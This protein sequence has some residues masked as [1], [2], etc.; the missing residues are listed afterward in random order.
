[1]PSAATL[2]QGI[3]LVNLGSPESTSVRHV[4]RY[5]REFLMDP[6]VIDVPYPARFAL[7]R[8]IITPF[9]AAKSAEAY[10]KV[11]TEEGSPLI[12]TSQRLTAR[13]QEKVGIPVR[14]A[15]RYGKPGIAEA[16]VQLSIAGVR[17]LIVIPLFPHYAMSSYES[18]VVEVRRVAEQNA[19]WLALSVVPPYFEHAAYL[20]ALVTAS[21]PYLRPDHHLLFSFHGVP[22]RHILKSDA[23]GCHCLKVQNCCETA[24]P[25]HA[26]CYRRQC[27]GTVNGF[28]RR[29]GLSPDAYSFSF[30]SRLGKDKWLEPATQDQL[31]RLAQSGVR[32]LTILCPAFTVDCLETLEEIGIRGR[33]T[34]VAE[35]GAEFNLIPCLNDHPVWVQALAA[36]AREHGLIPVIENMTTGVSN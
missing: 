11:W 32:K 8:G 7:V 31:V 16:L 15:M 17:R 27:I 2:K 3:L 9:R 12:T 33:E 36:M 6:R 25:A 21:Q 23:R 24:S 22:Q 34:F 19:P 5:L 4:R 30:Q 35:G 20:D 18:A 13:L 26:T 14:L 10:R 1:M 28:A 29:A